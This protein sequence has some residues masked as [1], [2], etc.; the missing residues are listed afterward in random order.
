MGLMSCLNK[1]DCYQ[2]AHLC[3]L[4]SIFSVSV[5]CTQGTQKI[6]AVLM[7]YKTLIMCCLLATMVR[8]LKLSNLSVIAVFVH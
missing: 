6:V 4:T 1:L 2:S 7:Y 8:I 3:H 5:T